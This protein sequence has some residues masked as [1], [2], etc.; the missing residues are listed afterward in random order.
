MFT[1]HILRH[2]HLGHLNGYIGVP[3][4]HPW[5]GNFDTDNID[6]HGGITY[7]ALN[8]PQQDE[9]S[10]EGYWYLGFD[11]AHWCNTNDP[12]DEK[13]MRNELQKLKRQAEAAIF[14]ALI[15]S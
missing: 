14:G 1:L 6:V 2:S 7:S 4:G 10:Q 5:Y 3:R 13:F 12:K 11:T 15:Q 8:L 9:G